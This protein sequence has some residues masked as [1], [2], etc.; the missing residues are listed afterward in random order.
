M[1]PLNMFTTFFDNYTSI[2][3]F[4]SLVACEPVVVY[5]YFNATWQKHDS[6]SL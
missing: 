6:N 1:W 2:L 3:G 5:R 4:E